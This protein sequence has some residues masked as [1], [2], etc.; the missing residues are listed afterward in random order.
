M[1]EQFR[2]KCKAVGREMADWKKL[3]GILAIVLLVAVDL[4]TK[5]IV[6]GGATA[7]NYPLGKVICVVIPGFLQFTPTH[8]PGAAFSILSGKEWAQAF[9]IVLTSV[10]CVLLLLWYLATPRKSKL[11]R[12]ALLLIIAG[13]IGNLVDRIAY[14][15]VRDFFDFPWLANCNFADFCITGGGAVLIFY[16]L[17]WSDDAVFPLRKLV[18]KENKAQAATPDAPP[19]PE[20]P[21]PDSEIQASK[22]YAD[23]EVRTVEIGKAQDSE[24]KDG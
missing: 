15:F 14:G 23:I 11:L 10:C 1:K 20:S 4:I 6:C 9:F 5:Y 17:L 8:N 12:S 16:L 2:E 21:S 13:A 19:M 3:D 7:G 18:K 22:R 24:D